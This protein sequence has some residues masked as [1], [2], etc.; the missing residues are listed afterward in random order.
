MGQRSFSR[1]LTLKDQLFGC[2]N[3]GHNVMYFHNVKGQYKG[4][5]KAQSSRCNDAPNN[6]YFFALPSRGKQ[7]TSP[8]VP[9]DKF[10]VF[11]IDEYA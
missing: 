11:S 5:C 6:N 10:K 9:T 8:D 1:R 7:E 3:S 4:S 2:R